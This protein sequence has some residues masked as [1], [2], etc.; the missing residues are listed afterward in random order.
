[1]EQILDKF[2]ILRSARFVRVQFLDAINIV[3]YRV[4]PINSFLSLLAKDQSRLPISKVVLGLAFSTVAEG[5]TASGEYHLV[6]DLT[7]LK[8]LQYKPGHV[9]CMSFFEEKGD[10]PKP[11]D[12][13]PRSVLRKSVE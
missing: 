8:G 11:V 5:F 13:C 3:R 6:P 12:I 10:I 1:M 7:S 9:S 4:F 2:P